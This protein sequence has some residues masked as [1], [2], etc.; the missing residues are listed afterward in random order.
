MPAKIISESDEGIRLEVYVPY[1]KSMLEGEELIQSVLNEAGCLVSSSFLKR[2]DS[3]GTPIRV[4]GRKLTSKGEET[5]R[6][7]SPFGEIVVA[8]HVYQGSEG[9]A[10]YVPLEERARIVLTSTPKFAKTLSNKYA[11]QPATSVV[12]DLQENHGREVSRGL[13]Q[14]TSEYVAAGILSKEES[15][16]YDLPVLKGTV[17]SIGVGMDGA[18]L[19]IRDDGWREGMVGSFTLYDSHGERLESI[20]VAA[21]PEYGKERF[22]DAMKG[23]LEF[24]SQ[25]FPQALKV[26]V[27]DGAKI[28]WNFL[29]ELTDIQVL[30]FFHASE[31]VNRAAEVLFSNSKRRQKEWAETSCQKLKYCENGASELLDEL[32]E[33]VH[34]VT[35]KKAQEK[36][37]A[38][39]TY[40][41]NNL[42][43]MAYKSVADLDLPIGSG[44]TEAAAKT[45]IKQRLC[46][47]GMRWLNQGVETILALRTL[48]QSG[49]EWSQFWQKI[50]Q[51]GFPCL[52]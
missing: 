39:I 49:T 26:G 16:T 46:L 21:A 35:G 31:Y 2:F 12:K 11:S 47:S 18:M 3:D 42:K 4:G 37:T 45:I 19:N 28:N 34:A 40:F 33:R 43:R 30:D 24:L 10:T 15:W 8:R 52:A 41:E 17:A 25:Q 36:L 29:D 1:G 22:L 44:V 6:Y 20:Y 27:A 13:V 14:A 48:A 9:G 32:K 38:V 51:Y 50:S 23:K 7:Q 5:K